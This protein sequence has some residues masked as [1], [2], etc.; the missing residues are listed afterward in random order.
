MQGRRAMREAGMT[1]FVLVRAAR[2]WKIE[3]WT[4]TSP[5]A[6]ATK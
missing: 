3:S 2:A 4:W 6:V 1:A 5:K